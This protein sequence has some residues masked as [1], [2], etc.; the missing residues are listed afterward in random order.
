MIIASIN[1]GQLTS[2][3]GREKKCR[4]YL[5]GNPIIAST[6]LD[7]N[8]HAALYVPF[9]VALFEGEG[10]EGSRISFDRP[11]S[12]LALLGDAKIDE[13]GRQLDAKIDAAVSAVCGSA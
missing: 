5:V 13:I 12:S 8:P 3:S 4:L 1:Q 10:A 2:L 7:I 9:R 6:I 11:G